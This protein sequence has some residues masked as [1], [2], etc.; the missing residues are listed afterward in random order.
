MRGLG[1]A[2]RWLGTTREGETEGGGGGN[3]EKGGGGLRHGRRVK[4]W[5]RVRVTTH[6]K[7]RGRLCRRRHWEDVHVRGA[8]KS[9]ATGKGRWYVLFMAVVAAL[10][11][12]LV[13]RE[14]TRRRMTL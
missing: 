4:G 3:R 9:A 8:G 1:S 12:E 2:G 6:N 13:A 11:R 14:K 10:E 5:V 7:Q